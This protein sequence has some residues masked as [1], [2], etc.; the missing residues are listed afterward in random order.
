MPN[1]DLFWNLDCLDLGH[2]RLKLFFHLQNKGGSLPTSQY[3]PPPFGFGNRSFKNGK[4]AICNRGH[5]K[6]IK[7]KGKKG[8]KGK[9]KE[10]YDLIVNI[11]LVRFLLHSV[12]IREIYCHSYFTWNQ[13]PTTTFKIQ[14]ASQN[15]I[16]VKIV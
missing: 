12:E 7:V 15:W 3:P 8:K 10:T 13:F 16:H 5:V 4:P 1:L 11:D 6:H 14:T 9:A 2:C